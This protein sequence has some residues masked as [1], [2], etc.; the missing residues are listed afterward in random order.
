VIAL[1]TDQ[2]YEG[3]KHLRESIMGNIEITV[4]WLPDRTGVAE[5]EKPSVAEVARPSEEISAA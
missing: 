2:D 1:D 5:S 4:D 3:L